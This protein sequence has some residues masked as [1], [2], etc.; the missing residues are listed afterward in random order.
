MTKQALVQKKLFLLNFLTTKCRFKHRH[1]YHVDMTFQVSSHLLFNIQ[2]QE[3]IQPPFLTLREYE[4]KIMK[5]NLFPTILYKNLKISKQSPRKKHNTIMKN[6]I[7]K[8]I[9]FNI[10]KH[11]GD[12]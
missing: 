3:D 2:L 4:T 10:I 7:Q 12:G 6:R 1:Y 5:V 8:Y 9:T 11:H